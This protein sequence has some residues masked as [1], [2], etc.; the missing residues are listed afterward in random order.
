MRV[1]R[2]HRNIALS[3][4]SPT[5]TGKLLLDR[6]MWRAQTASGPKTISSTAIP[7]HRE[8][9][10]TGVRAALTPDLTG[11]AEPQSP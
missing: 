9:G 3:S 5:G 4:W 2:V 10:N 11:S 7:G 6:E 8:P 1:A